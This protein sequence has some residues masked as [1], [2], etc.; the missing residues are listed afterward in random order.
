MPIRET[1]GLNEDGSRRHGL[2][3]MSSIRGA[4]SLRQAQFRHLT[5]EPRF[6]PLG[7]FCELTQRVHVM[8]EIV[9]P[10]PSERAVSQS[11]RHRVG[12]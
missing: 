7:A 8:L 10:G 6:Q 5:R 12:G 9:V 4:E 11:S 2:R 1:D 3:H